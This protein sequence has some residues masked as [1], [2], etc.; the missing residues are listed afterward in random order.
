MLI[1]DNVEIKYEP[2]DFL[3]TRLVYHDYTHDFYIDHDVI[4]NC[5]YPTLTITERKTFKSK[6]YSQFSHETVP[7]NFQELIKEIFEVYEVAIIMPHLLVNSDK[8]EYKNH[9]KLGGWIWLIKIK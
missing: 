1:E 4:E 6:T 3:Y 7:E 5:I 9:I 8:Y 2:D